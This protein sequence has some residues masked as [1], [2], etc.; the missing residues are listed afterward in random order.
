MSKFKV[1]STINIKG[2]KMLTRVCSGCSFYEDKVLIL[3]NEKSEWVLPKGYK[4][5]RLAQ[6]VNRKGKKLSR[7][8]CDQYVCRRNLLRV[9]LCH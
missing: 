6:E 2:I 3:K 8:Q 4:T 9:L 1:G 7:C 5:G